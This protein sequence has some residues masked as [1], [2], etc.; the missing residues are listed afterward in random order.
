MKTCCHCKQ[1]KSTDSFTKRS[2]SKD[3]HH[4]YCRE[5]SKKFSAKFEL[6]NPDYKL[7][8]NYGI[9][10]EDYTS[11]LKN[12][13]HSCAVCCT[14]QKSISRALD[15]DHDHQSGKV[16]GLLCNKCNQALGLLKDNLQYITNLRN[17]LEKSEHNV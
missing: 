3:G 13:N 11:M 12:Q 16:R 2:Q 8:K 5:C 17:Y 4:Y 14:P 7:M 15:V 6:D 1:H 9:S 10:K